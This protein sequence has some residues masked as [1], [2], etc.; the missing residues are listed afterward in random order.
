VFQ[1]RNVDPS[2]F[3][4]DPELPGMLYRPVS[5]IWLDGGTAPDVP[6]FGSNETVQYVT[7]VGG[8]VTGTVVVDAGSVVEVVDVVVVT[9]S[10]SQIAYRVMSVVMG[11]VVAPVA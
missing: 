5:K 7:G 6:P 11:L 2:D 3:A 8:D 4:S 1:P 9:S 10:A